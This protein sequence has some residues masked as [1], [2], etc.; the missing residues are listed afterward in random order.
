M[1]INKSKPVAKVVIKSGLVIALPQG[2]L[3]VFLLKYRNTVSPENWL[4]KVC[5]IFPVLKKTSNLS[6]K[7]HEAGLRFLVGTT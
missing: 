4:T 2:P 7:G 3:Y 5:P 6:A 1:D